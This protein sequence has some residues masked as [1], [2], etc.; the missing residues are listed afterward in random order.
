[1][2][3]LFFVLSF[4]FLLTNKQKGMGVDPILLESSFEDSSDFKKW[5]KETC[6]PG[7]LLISTEVARKGKSSARFEF[8]KADVKDYS[9]YVRA[10]LRLGSETDNERW[11]GFSNY[12]PKDFVTD[13]LAEKIA[14]WHE[15]P[16][17]DLGESWR[18]PPISLGIENERFYVQILWA[19]APV[20]TNKSKDGEKKVDLGPIDKN[21]WNDWVFHIRFSWRSDGIIEIWKNKQK[22]FSYNG[23]NSFNDKH[24]PYFKIGI[25]KWGWNGWAQYSPEEKRVLFYDE[26]RI[27]NRYANLNLVSPK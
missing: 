19:A 27:G 6:R 16:D 8:T 3:M 14:Q 10:E 24:L 1:M 5:T 20:N 25:Y 15:I 4:L 13:P 12:L 23:P 21:K 26:V 18:S 7:A 17:W 9:G 2:P 22:I 11:Y